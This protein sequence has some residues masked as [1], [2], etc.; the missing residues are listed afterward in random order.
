[1]V[2][3]RTLA[4]WLCLN[5]PTP[6]KNGRINTAAHYVLASLL[7]SPAVAGMQTVAIESVWPAVSGPGLHA[8]LLTIALGRMV[9]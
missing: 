7:S 9:P 6:E 3:P 5:P 1:M 4:L 2:S 8:H